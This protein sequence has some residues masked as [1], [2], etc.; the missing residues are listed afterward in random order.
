MSTWIDDRTRG[1]ALLGLNISLT[2]D[3]LKHWSEASAL[4]FDYLRLLR[5]QSHD[6]KQVFED[7]Q[8]LSNVK[9]RYRQPRDSLV[10]V[11]HL[12]YRLRYPVPRSK[13]LSSATTFEE[14]NSSFINT[15]LEHLQ[16][17]NAIVFLESQELP[18]KGP[19]AFTSTEPIFGGRFTVDSLQKLVQLGDTIDP[20]LHLPHPNP[21]I[22]RDFDLT[23]PETV[24]EAPL[25]LSDT[26]HSRLWYKND[27]TFL[28]PKSEIRIKLQSP[29]I[30][31]SPRG[32]ALSALLIELT[33]HAFSTEEGDATLA[34]FSYTAGAV[35]DTLRFRIS[36]FTDK[37]DFFV[38]RIIFTLLNFALDTTT[39]GNVVDQLKRDLK[40][41]LFEPPYLVVYREAPK[42][43]VET[44]W[45]QE[46]LI[47]ELDSGSLGRAKW[48]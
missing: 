44:Y 34:G 32:A 15:A 22:P 11:K 10:H 6:L 17:E 4:V 8:Q 41:E 27:T 36:G 38:G 35:H 14:Y 45:S 21:F 25:L 13:I 43:L 20:T 47:Q 31:A 46:E 18:A 3:G 19:P 37:L 5:Q 24:S 2:P 28:L 40:N 39:F 29:L 7:R 30:N 23:P 12:V 16:I 48:R 26:A 42:L 9:F 33:D 1:Y